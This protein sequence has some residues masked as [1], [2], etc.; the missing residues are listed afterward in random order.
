MR[1]AITGRDSTARNYA[2]YA[3]YANYGDTPITVTVHLID[4]PITVTQLRN[5][6]D[7]AFN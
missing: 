6:G 5:Y 4:L 3:N 2:N 7:S 1:A